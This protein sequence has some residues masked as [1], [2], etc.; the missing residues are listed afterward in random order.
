METNLPLQFVASFLALATAG[1]LICS[2]LIYKHYKKKRAPLI[3][4][5]HHDCSVVTESKWS[6]IFYF[7][8]ET[9]GGLY[10]VSMLVG[11]VTTLW[12]ETLGELFLKLLPFAT[13]FGIFF[14]AFLVGVQVFKIKDYCFYC[15]L[16]AL[17]TV[18]LFVNSLALL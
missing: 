10:Y 15:M 16:S 17:L 4:P 7:R 18:L 8:N 12:S 5:L 1:I 13:G 6:H 3:C 9:L 11:M 14:S 2:F